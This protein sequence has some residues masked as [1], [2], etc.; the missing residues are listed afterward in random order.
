MEKEKNK[1]QLRLKL[2]G[3]ILLAVV[4]G[5]LAG[6][7]GE[8]IARFYLSNFAFFRD[9]YFTETDNLGQNEIIIREPR[10]VVVEQSLRLDQVKNDVQPSIMKIY[11]KKRTA[12]N[13]LDKILLPEDYLGQAVVLTSDGWLMATKNQLV[14]PKE[15]LITGSA[16]K[17]Y[18]VENVVTDEITKIMFIKINAQNL[19]VTKLADL[20]K[21]T[22]GEQVVVY[23]SNL[24]WLN[25]A[26]I[27]NKRY[28]EINYKYDFVSNTQVLD[29]FILLDKSFTSDF[30]G[31]PVFNFQSEL[32]GFLTGQDESISLAIPINYI[33]PIINQVLKEEPI[34]RPY[35]GINYIDLSKA[36]GL[37][38][39]E[40]Q[41]ANQGALLWPNERGIAIMSDSPLYNKLAKGDI[42]ISVENQT[43]DANNDL[44]DLLLQ[45]KSGQ[46]IRIKYWHQQK[47]AELNLTLK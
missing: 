34:K 14:R 9:L 21:V 19:P 5:F 13:L 8:F 31:T 16:Q 24:D 23:N 43:L 12:K 18:E 27:Q 29:K 1:P 3:F 41:Q 17:I 39:I 11:S 26:N 35:L 33:S 7:S 44:T 22:N 32:M 45:Y 25:L 42:I 47:E 30:N 37:E 2:I 36:Y 46:D 4:F 40:R 38:D 6:I 15:S 20:E 28:K 10:K